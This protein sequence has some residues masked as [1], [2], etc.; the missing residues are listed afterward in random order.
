M[1]SLGVMLQSI[2]D[3]FVAELNVVFTRIWIVNKTQDKLILQA[4]SGL[5][6]HIEG[7]HQTLPI[8]GDS[9][10]SRVVAIVLIIQLFVKYLQL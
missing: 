10:I 3:I 9:K 5:Y 1:I 8:G 7:N 4:S 2:S 6:S